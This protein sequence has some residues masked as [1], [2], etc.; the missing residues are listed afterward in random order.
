MPLKARSKALLSSPDLPISQSRLWPRYLRN[1]HPKSKREKSFRRSLQSLVEKVAVA[2]TPHEEEERIPPKLPRLWRKRSLFWVE[3]L[4]IA[5]RPRMLR[6]GLRLRPSCA[7]FE[8]RDHLVFHQWTR[9]LDR[10]GKR[11]S[12]R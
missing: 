3:E 12:P 2:P 9:S 1:T 5:T 6:R 4:K 8:R 11:D 7:R 10:C